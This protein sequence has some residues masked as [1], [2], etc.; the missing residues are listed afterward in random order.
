MA[1]TPKRMPPKRAK[2][3]SLPPSRPTAQK[4][5]SPWTRFRQSVSRRLATPRRKMAAAL[6]VGSLALGSFG[7]Y[8]GIQAYRFHRFRE[9]VALSVHLG[10][11]DRAADLSGVDQLLKTQAQSGA[12]FDFIVLESS[13]S[14]A[15]ERAYSEKATNE[16]AEF[17]RR[18]ARFS[19]ENKSAEEMAEV[20]FSATGGG[21]NRT[22]SFQA[23]A[24]GLAVKY[25]LPIKI[26]E[27]HSLA[28]ARKLKEMEPILDEG[29]WIE[30]LGS[31]APTLDVWKRVLAFEPQYRAYLRMRDQNIAATVQNSAAELR[32][33]KPA[34]RKKPLRGLLVVGSA[35]HGVLSELQER[36]PKNFSSQMVLDPE[37]KLGS[38]LVDV[39]MASKEDDLMV[40]RLTV[41]A[42]LQPYYNSL[43]LK[44]NFS[45]AQQLANVLSNLSEKRA[46]EL[47]QSVRDVKG[48]ERGERLLRALPPPSSARSN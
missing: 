21:F 31:D 48:K 9:G 36:T 29:K 44:R 43:Y 30:H 35:H 2:K 20:V 38:L 37:A 23:G 28:N 47:I 4:S 39:R 46:G 34:L 5:A 14:T 42:F 11:H 3:S 17:I 27:E 25:N 22:Q 24:I 18:K 7:A 45:R 33:Q 8:K 41:A 19:F 13:G 6:L 16:I 1:R 32:L 10:F 40:N 26:A 12:P 15:A